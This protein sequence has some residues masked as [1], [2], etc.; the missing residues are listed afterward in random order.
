MDPFLQDDFS[1][2]MNLFNDETAIAP[3]EYVVGFNVRNRT[4]CLESVSDAVQDTTVPDGL[5]QGIYA[6]DKYII[7]FNGGLAYYKN[8]ETD[9]AWTQIAGF[10]MTADADRIYAEPIPENTLNASRKLADADKMNGSQLVLGINL[11]PLE[12]PAA[13]GGLV[14][15]DG[16][17]QGWLISS[18]GTA[19][20]LK[21]YFE[22]TQADREYVPVM[23]M[24]KYINGI[25]I[26][27]SGNG[28]TLY[29]SVSGR[30]LDFVV[31]VDINGDKG[32]GASTTSYA[33]SPYDVTCLAALNSGE[34]FVGT[35]KTCHVVAF[36]YDLTIFGEP[37]F[38][39]K[40]FG[41]G[42]TNHFSFLDNNGDYTWVDKDGLR[43]FNAVSSD[44]DEGRT[45]IFSIKITRAFEQKINRMVQPILQDPTK[46]TAIT[47][48]NYSLYSVLTTYGN[49]IAVYDNARQVWTS[50]D[51]LNLD[52][53]VKQFAVADQSDNPTLYAI[54]AASVYKLYASAIFL[55]AEVRLRGITSGLCSVRLRPSY[56][57]SN[58]EGSAD[59]VRVTMGMMVDNL[60]LT[61]LTQPLEGDEG[62]DTNTFN[63][64]A[65]SVRQ[66]WK[67][68][69]RIKWQ[70]AATLNQAEVSFTPIT[71]KVAPKQA[72][73]VYAQS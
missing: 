55:Q 2:G 39:N 62:I 17:T 72:G 68:Q 30:P 49:V 38:S 31:N 37:T 51:I 69:P 52:G 12:I 45:S 28:K 59:A 16:T 53:P 56:A 58:L 65:T 10:A 60:Y 20:I 36:N 67:V 3:N 23:K 5:K 44:K 50:F 26:G 41:V 19:R 43:S 22:W 25:L 73:Q 47:Y 35:L 66:G 21:R 42:V 32:G 64:N 29:R 54:T 33:V 48:H 8:I 15:M 18:D 13:A 34:L 63:F 27:V 6:F 24:M 1:G 11:F 57:W 40:T 71:S 46:T 4:T 9:S 70:T 61:E 7:L 14:C